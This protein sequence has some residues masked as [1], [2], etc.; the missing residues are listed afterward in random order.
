MGC[1]F[2]SSSVNFYVSAWQQMSCA[3]NNATSGG[4]QELSVARLEMVK[5][6]TK[7]SK[8]AYLEDNYEIGNRPMGVLSTVRARATRRDVRETP[9]TTLKGGITSL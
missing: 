2:F 5:Y 9:F 8:W 3:L 1:F 6:R 7:G 4:G